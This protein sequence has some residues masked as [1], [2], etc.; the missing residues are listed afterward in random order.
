LRVTAMANGYVASTLRVSQ[1]NRAAAV[2]ALSPGYRALVSV[3]LPA[4]P[5]P[6]LVRVLNGAGQ[7]LDALLDGASDRGI[8]PPGRL[9]L[10]PL[11][12][13]DYMIDLRGAREQRQ[14]GIKIVDRDVVATFR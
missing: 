7:T 11:P 3:E 12:P 5:G 6:L 14:E 13:G 8:E 4:T 2:L 9:S 1:D 10:G